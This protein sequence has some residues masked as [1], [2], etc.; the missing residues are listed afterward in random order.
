MSISC[1]PAFTASSVSAILIEV[2]LCPDGKAV[3][4]EATLTWLPRR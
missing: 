2:K 1:A 3:A 4:T